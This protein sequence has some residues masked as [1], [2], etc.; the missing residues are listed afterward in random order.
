MYDMT[1][2]ATT[3]N[4]QVAPEG[5]YTGFIHDIKFY[6]AKEGKQY[7]FASIG[8]TINKAN[9]PGLSKYK[10]DFAT[11]ISADPSVMWRLV[12]MYRSAGLTPEAFNTFEDA[13]RPLLHKDVMFEINHK[14]RRDNDGVQEN[15]K[16][17]LMNDNAHTNHIEQILTNDQGLS[18]GDMPESPATDAQPS[19]F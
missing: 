1:T 15:V 5:V 8:V 3:S 16:K 4:P 7:G 19:L 11:M 18:V 9:H 12:E 2:I 10:I 17:F 6:P 13:V 14:P